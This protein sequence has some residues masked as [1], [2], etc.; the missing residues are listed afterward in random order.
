MRIA[1]TAT[2]SLLTIFGI[3]AVIGGYLLASFLPEHFFREVPSKHHE[4]FR[5]SARA[6]HLAAVIEAQNMPIPAG[7][8]IIDMGVQPQTV[9]NAIRPYGLVWTLLNE[10]HVEV[11]WA[12]N[13]NKTKDGVDFNYNGKAFKGGPFIISATQ[14]T[15]QVDQV[16]EQWKN[17]GVQVVTTTSDF[18]APVEKILK[19]SIHWTLDAQNGKIAE[20][21]L[22]KALIPQRAYDWIAPSLLDCCHDVFVMPHADPKWS[23]HGNLLT[24][25][26]P[27]SEGGC[28]GWIWAGCRASSELEN[29]SNPA[30]SSERLNFLM[31]TPGNGA[32]PALS[33]AEHSDASPP[34]QYDFP[35]HPIMQ[36]LGGV[37]GAHENGN[38]QVYLP[39]TG[40]RPTTMVGVWDPTHSNVPSKSPGKA[41]IIAFGTAFGDS[42]RGMVMY[43]AGHQL[44]KKSDEAN[45]AAMRAFFN[46]SLLAASGSDKSI[47]VTAT[48][49]AQQVKGG[50]PV[51]VS[52]T[53][54]GGD[55][56]F[57]YEWSSSC[58]GQFSNP[59]A[60]STTF[61]P[62][63]VSKV[64]PCLIT[65]SVSD[66]CYTRSAFD[67]VE[68]TLLA[69]EVCGN[70][71]DD[72]GDG[73]VDCADSDCQGERY[74]SAIVLD[75]DVSDEDVAL[76]APDDDGAK[77]YDQGDALAVDMQLYIPAGKTFYVRWKNNENGSKAPEILIETSEDGN[78][79]SKVAGTPFEVV[80]KEYYNE[81]FTTPAPARYI[82]FTS[83]NKYNLRLDAVIYDPV[84][85]VEICGNGIDDDGDGF[86]DCDDSDC[87]NPVYAS[88]VL[89]DEGV[90]YASEALGSPDDNA[91]RL[92]DEGD[93][94]VLD[95][96]ISIPANGK[97]AIRWRR[98]PGTSADP[99][100]KVELSNDGNN[101]TQAA[102]SPF[103]FTSTTYFITELTAAVPFRFIRF[104][105]LNAYNV[106]LD[107]VWYLPSCSTEDCTNG[108]DDDGDGLIDCADPGC[109]NVCQPDTCS[110]RITQGLV[111][112]YNFKQSSGSTI[113]DVAPSGVPLHLTIQHPANVQW[114]EGCGMQITSATLAQ[115]EGAAT[116]LISSLKSA[117]AMTVE[118]WVRPSNLSQ[119]GPARIVTISKNPWERNFTLGQTGGSYVVR[120]RTTAGG[121]NNG[122]PEVKV[123]GATSAYPQHVVYSWNG[124]TGEEK[125]YLDGV[126]AYSGTRSGNLSNWDDSF[127]VA[128]GNEL[129]QDRSWLGDLYSVAFYNKVLSPSEI[130]QNFNQGP[131]CSG[132]L[133]EPTI[134]CGEN[135]SI[136]MLF[137]G[138]QNAVPKTLAISDEGTI[139]SIIV[140]IVY[141]SNNPGASILIFD[142]NNNPY[143]AARVPVGSN[144]WVY[145]TT[146]PATSA[147]KYLD[148]NAEAY[149][150]SITAY[151]FRHGVVGKSAVTQFT[152]IGG[153]NT[154]ETLH[155][156]L[157]QGIAPRNVTVR[158]PVSELT[159]DDRILNFTATAGDVGTS[160]TKKWGP[161]GLG[162]P[163]GCCIDVVEITLP[164]VAPET[165]LLTVEIN[166]PAGNG[167]SFV[168]GGTVWV[169][170]NCFTTTLNCNNVPNQLPLWVID[171]DKNGSDH[172]RLWAFYDYTNP[173]ETAVDFGRLKFI[174]PQTG[175]V[176]DIAQAGDIEAMAVNKYTG[177]AYIFS[178]S[179]ISG[180]PS[181]T[182][183]LWTYDLHQ[184]EANKGNIILTLL[185]HVTQP[186]GHAMENLAFDPQT[187]RLYT[188]D[189]K[190]GDQN[191]SQTTDDLYYLDLTQLDADPMKTTPLVYV[192]PIKGLG[193]S[194]DYV[195]GMEM[196]ND[197]RLYV[198]DGTDQEL[199]EIDP[200]TGSIIAIADGHIPGGVASNTDV[201][202]LTWDF[203]HNQMIAID[204]YNHKFIEVTLGSDGN[205]I[206]LATFTGA[207]GMPSD[208]DFEASAMFNAC[209]AVKVGIGNIVFYDVNKNKKYDAGEGKDYVKVQLY[210]AGQTPGVSIPVA[211]TYTAFGGRYLFENLEEGSY[212][213]HI[214]ASNFQPGGPL[215][216]MFS[217]SGNGGDN[218]LD[219]DA[220]ENGIDVADPAISGISSVTITL[221]AGL[222]PTNATSETGA[223]NTLDDAN[224]DRYDLTVDFGFQAGELC[225]N[226]IDDDG[227]G[228][229]DCQD[230]ECSDHLVCNCMGLVNAGFEYQL[231]GWSVVKNVD[232]TTDASVG[233]LAGRLIDHQAQIYQRIP[234]A[235]SGAFEISAWA[236]VS[237]QAP[238]YAE[239]YMHFLDGNLNM[240]GSQVIQP[241]ASSVKEYHFFSFVGIAPAGAAWLEVGAY[242][243][244]NSGA[245]FVDEFCVSQA[246]W[247]PNQP[248]D[249]SCGCSENY[250]PNGGFEYLYQ[251]NF[252]TTFQGKPAMPLNNGNSTIKPWT[253]GL[254]SKYM[255]L[256]DDSA[257]TINNPEGN[258]FVWLPNANDCWVSNV[259]FSTNMKLED[260]QRYRICL[261]AASWAE[262]L[263]TNGLPTGGT[264]SQKAGIL[265]I[266]FTYAS[267]FK[268]AFAWSVPPSENFQQLNWKKLEY[269]FTYN[270][271]DPIA[272]LVFTSAR[273]DVGIAIDAVQLTRV[274]CPQPI[275]CPAGGLRYQKWAGIPGWD[276]QDLLT[277]PDFPNNYDETGFIQDFQWPANTDDAYGTRVWGYLIPPTDG[278]Y[279]FNLT[280]DD[281]A[282]LYLSSDEQASNKQLIAQVDGWTGV[283]EHSKFP[284]QT[285]QAVN[286][287]AGQKY[288]IELLH[289][290]GGGGDHFQVYW[291]K[292]GDANWS[293]IPAEALQPICYAENC[294]NGI[295]D[296]NDGLIDCQDPDCADGMQVELLVQP[297]SCGESFGSATVEMSGGDQPFSF[298]WSDLPETAM[299]TFEN[300]LNDIAGS[301]HPNGSVGYPIFT[302]EAVQGKSALYLDGNTY[303]RY[304]QDGGF[305]EVPFQQLTVA[306]WL[307]PDNV[308]GK[309]VIYEEGGGTNGLVVMLDNGSLTAAV[310]NSGIA[311]FAGNHSFPADGNW[312]HVAVVFDKGLFT[313]YLDGLPGST[314][315]TTFNAV[316]AHGNDG[317]IGGAVNGSSI[318][319]SGYFFKGK[320]DDFRYFYS[321]ALS[322]SDIEDLANGF[323]ERSALAPGPYSVTVSSAANCSHVEQ[324]YI[325]SSG[326][327]TDGGTIGSDE[328]RC[329]ITFN[330]APIIELTAP[331]GS[332]DAQ[333][334]YRWQRSTDGGQTWI[335]IPGANGKEYD[336]AGIA[337]QTWYRRAVQASG[338]DE[339]KYSN[340]VVK[341]FKQDLLDAGLIGG[342]QQN[343][344]AYD[345]GMISSLAPASGLPGAVPVY[346]WQKST[347]GVTWSNI[348]GAT[349]PTYDPGWITTTTWYRRAAVEQGCTDTLFTEPV[350]KYVVENITDPGAIA[351]D[352]EACG[353]FDPAA[354]ASVVDAEG[355]AWG[356]LQYQWQYSTDNYY[357]YDIPGAVFETYNPGTILKTT[358]YRRGARRSPCTTYTYSNVVVKMVVNNITDGGLIA[359][360]ES[361]CGAFDPGMIINDFDAEGGTGGYLVYQWQQ[362]TDGLLWQTIP[363][364][365]NPW[366]DPPAISQTT[367]YRRQARRTPCGS[368]INSNTVTK[369]VYPDLDAQISAAPT[370]QNGYLCDKVSY[371]FEAADQGAGTQYDWNFGNYA[372]PKSATGKGPH[373]VTWDV[374][375][376]APSYTATVS[377]SVSRDGC[378][379]STSQVFQIRPEITDVSITPTNPSS[380]GGNDGQI[381]VSATYPAGT[382]VEAS[383]DNGNTWQPLNLPFTGLEAGLYEVRVR[384]AGGACMQWVG[385]VALDEPNPPSA[386][387]NLSAGSICTGGQVHI[388]AIPSG[389]S[390]PS[391][392]W[393][394]GE[395][396]SPAVATGPGPHTITYSTNGKKNIQLLLSLNGCN[397]FIDTTLSVYQPLL[398]GGTIGSDE[399]MCGSKNPKEIISLTPPAGGSGGT[400]V[401]QWQM[402]TQNAGGAWSA[403]SDIP[404]ATAPSYE[405]QPISAP[406]QFRRKARLLECG[407]WVY[408]N[409]VTKREIKLPT[410]VNDN[411]TAACPG[412]VFYDD[413]S[414]NDE[415]K[416]EA[417]YSLLKQ[418]TNGIVEMEPSGEFFYT[419]NSTFCGYDYFSYR[420][421]VDGTN[422]CVEG[423]VTIDLT[424][425]EKPLLQ[426]IP[427]DLTIHCDEEMPLA[428]TVT[429]WENCQSV[430][431]SLEETA[432]LGI[433]SCSVYSYQL[434]RSWV[435]IDY[436]GNSISDN[437]VITIQDVT[438]PNIY[439]LYTLPNGKR[440]VAGV[441]HNVTHRWKTIGFPVQFSTPPIVLTQVVSNNQAAA[442]VTRLRNIS[443][444]QFQLRLQ[445][446]E[447]ADNVHAEESV[448]W[449]AIEPGAFSSDYSLEAGRK[450]VSSN[451]TTIAF[452]QALSNPGLLASIQTFNENNPAFPKLHSLTNTAATVS[453]QEETSLDPETNHGLEYMG[454]LAIAGDGK[455]KTQSGE[456]FGEFG[457]VLAGHLPVSVTLKHTYKNPVV[458]IGGFKGTAGPAT[459]RVEQLHSQGFSVRIQ[460]WDYLPNLYTPEL[461]TY[462]VVEGSVP[463]DQT[464]E[465]SQIPKALNYGTEI[466]VVDNCDL[467]VPLTIIE[468]PFQ[469]NCQ[470]DV[471]A[472]TY[473]AQDEC[474]NITQYVQRFTLQ[475][476][477]PPTFTVPS[478]TLLPCNVD[479]HNLA[480][481]GDVTDEADNCATNLEATY[482]D[483]YNFLDG[484]NGYILR[485][486]RLM[487]RCGNVVTKVQKITLFYNND[488]DGDGIPDPF[489]LDDD[490]DGIPDVD[491][492][493]DDRD[494]DG[495][496]N[497]ID[498]DTDNDGTPDITETGFIDQS[499]DGIVDTYGLPDWDTDG[500]GLANEYDANDLDTTLLASDS[501]DPSAFQ[502]DRDG[503]G[504][505]NFLDSDS[506][507]DG[508]PDI[509]ENGGLDTNGDG[510]IDYPVP[511]NPGSMPDADGDG[512]CDWYDTDTDGVYGLD[513]LNRAL[514]YTSNGKLK[515]GTPGFNPDFDYDGIPDFLDLDSDNDGIPDLIEALGVDSD[516]NGRIDPSEFKDLNG[517]GFHDLYEANPLVTTDPQQP[518]NINGRPYD[519][520]DNNS[521]TSDDRDGDGS[522][523]RRDLDSDDDGIK[524]ILEVGNFDYDSNLDGVA[525]SF[526]DA[527]SDGM[528]DP[529]V[530]TCFTEVDGLIANGRPED[531]LDLNTSIYGSIYAD[532]TFGDLNNEPDVDDDADNIPNFLDVDSDNDLL[533]DSIEDKNRNGR[534]DEGETGYLDEDSDDDYILDGI[535]DAD[536]DG[537]YDV[538]PETDPLNP[539]TDGDTLID[540]VEDA[541]QDGEVDEPLESDPRDP[542]DPYLNANCI[543]VAIQLKV[544]LSGA[545]LQNGNSPLMR[546]DLRKK[547]LVP[548]TEPYSGMPAFQNLE[549][550]SQPPVATDLLQDKAD[551]SVVDWV[552]IE[553]RP[554]SAP[555]NVADTRT[556]LVQRNGDVIDRNGLP[557]IYFDSI[558][559]GHYYVVVRHRNHLGVT[560]ANPVLLSP[561]PRFLDYTHPDTVFY[562]THPV[563]IQN[564]N[565]RALWVGDL[566]GDHKVIY[567]GPMNDIF[568][569]FFFVMTQEDNTQNLANF[570]AQGYTPYDVN[571]DGKAIY[572]GPNND[573]SMVLFY[574]ILKHPENASLLAN[575][576]VLEKLP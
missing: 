310:K 87:Q 13:P 292:P 220:D 470:G 188:A 356:Q 6:E 2:Q 232:V 357:W 489:D 158:L 307:K 86:T 45:I 235:T 546:D 514:L 284:T 494:G 237:Q 549:P 133:F 165:Q 570:I 41:A 189:P 4:E 122:M 498:L 74:A 517:T 358:Y 537:I 227:D 100:I 541:N 409:E 198:A 354:I 59:T 160:L 244:G 29:I 182:Q 392:S 540:G 263:G 12:I 90:A 119:S 141:K 210:A 193:E 576:I 372:S 466:F 565:E 202:S 96:G 468:S 243:E 337:V 156:P 495:I 47:Q 500:D 463:F 471:Y 507:N 427:A 17:L 437:Q 107:A 373:T 423:Q 486:W 424:D 335:D 64:S 560:T 338:C 312:H 564:G 369:T 506:D 270:G 111:A 219:D 334:I 37:E 371:T 299:Y 490:N 516:G 33:S 250:L 108:I 493:D 269:E 241:I 382:T 248:T 282:A 138:L 278:N 26:A 529:L 462:V 180:A 289:K 408:S 478:D 280:S 14:R 239:L 503:D 433:D 238:E 75:K 300:T 327:F 477:T 16:I 308:S 8:F 313:L 52:A 66:G 65:V 520:D 172:L 453:C 413:V 11:L 103:S 333:P 56:N 195:D 454:Y 359:G 411:Y 83:Q 181:K 77:L 555:K 173:V 330:P 186:S 467:T 97:Y 303:I 166:S 79:Y 211:E 502:H 297:A 257:N 504:I 253:P 191:S 203:L 476:T 245:L 400:T 135:R 18:E 247:P 383:I 527:N 168:I 366:Y 104:T 49:A 114:K 130:Q 197:G 287:L 230:P 401:Y 523:N 153:Y 63:S 513:D 418:A 199:Y 422:C 492:G 102:G 530:G 170:I 178:S 344:G 304:S 149:A 296:D 316:G 183:S 265:N 573:R 267:G 345:P 305:M 441:M 406:T 417:T 309:Q 534:Q 302:S 274:D 425:K 518:E 272:N 524:D 258:Y 571:L 162:F 482:S 399:D 21:Y 89:T 512:F 127:Q 76:G 496:P 175:A 283:T 381:S 209:E 32:L 497:Y 30:N 377:L 536:K 174:H 349:L 363:G 251:P 460:P 438:A 194:N 139:D 575:F 148:E 324:F 152:T 384:Y 5:A 110:N 154:T 118:A 551:Q 36:F 572:Q 125:I 22:K 412:F 367:R 268:T 519:F 568:S 473:Y 455:I 328:I 569:M 169:E 394:F 533:P 163:K 566:N 259:D 360:D 88:K 43:E 322:S 543:G 262:P 538:G 15:P 488:N 465:C 113:Y 147:I 73:L 92:Y 368:W 19:H 252:S 229:T 509:I 28:G 120:N 347:D 40:W 374:P 331:A 361:N 31:Q 370:G 23:T 221:K 137:E 388:E 81:A 123:N 290:E 332:P 416:G 234:L 547:L 348:A 352:E 431:I 390:S 558:P 474:G 336:P 242:K 80:N 548:L 279:V 84:C 293:I 402:R 281:D 27:L 435:A 407:D 403:W 439:R 112:L 99:L 264:I 70:G 53:A 205:N 442:V 98:D 128:F 131:C 301:N 458:I 185:G 35:T 499:G 212:I 475:D 323:A 342:D 385:T 446:E 121:D 3:G 144:A 190:D 25:N 192:G 457:T 187:N 434:T 464:V 472:R 491:E 260:G 535:E 176:T 511:G 395:G 286:L 419:P 145:R 315:I 94:L 378:E 479:I 9:E 68:L 393:I 510:V 376:N 508:I 429:A 550:G 505:P 353:P 380:C 387:V 136:E 126:L 459:V 563:A 236:K 295:D 421:C 225:G 261:Y 559:S 397:K 522:P 447:N 134:A 201:E 233:T 428:P 355:G 553:L 561:I 82:R 246:P 240:L 159:Y 562:G 216:N 71:L 20:N 157:P 55:G 430:S 146:L 294:S 443:T 101:F 436:C 140:E 451:P 285:S 484:C 325:S 67:N 320:I 231:Q 150:Q 379:A 445:E 213:V 542:C 317:G 574:T 329:G 291:K 449:I 521:L 105:T 207:P 106:D 109:G 224:D 318:T 200:Q 273:Q 78:T 487:D 469:F 60:P 515:S 525:D 485:T 531:G 91:A 554:S 58:G 526:A 444:T 38:E 256:I 426:G 218:Q 391:M 10:H 142:Q 448:A 69:D 249:L 415:L 298:R 450:L 375:N 319:G 95:M 61:T 404:G 440:L 46:F 567:Q 343:C 1:N 48:S 398:D 326:N 222:E 266:E 480:I 129:T 311:F 85:E 184:A 228:L 362:S 483:N 7:S 414:E 214:P 544:K 116:K 132:S 340:I 226:G 306:F 50:T 339:W 39:R 115:S 545:M 539:D 167:Q 217:I 215:E 143:T 351:G 364:A 481:T 171:E 62:P 532:G 204:N 254:T 93:L 557:I 34:Y 405:P 276:L 420:V 432:T 177:Q 57:T 552:F 461:L 164:D 206:A 456:V 410:V 365:T 42:N 196:T 151:L 277:N 24:W 161:N 72:D 314:T 346:V 271:L 275:D 155:F 223:F 452:S 396:A 556:A 51:N 117:N 208:P 501:Y 54:A 288:Y 255:F 124:A 179:R 44:D 341:G 386:T 528:S 389:S 321:L 350:V